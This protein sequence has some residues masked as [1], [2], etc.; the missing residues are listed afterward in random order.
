MMVRLAEPHSGLITHLS[1]ALNFNM[2]M[3]GPNQN[4]QRRHHT[5]AE[6]VSEIKLNARKIGRAHV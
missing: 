2:L 5:S 1:D 4:F 3:I 6:E